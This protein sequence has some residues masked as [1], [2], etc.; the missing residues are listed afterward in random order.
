MFSGNEFELYSED[1]ITASTFSNVFSSSSYDAA[2]GKFNSQTVDEIVKDFL[3]ESC[4]G[5]DSLYIRS[6][7]KEQY[8]KAVR[9]KILE[10][11]EDWLTKLTSFFGW[12]NQVRFQLDEKGEVTYEPLTGLRILLNFVGWQSGKKFF[13]RQII[14]F[15]TAFIYTV[16]KNIFWVV[17]TTLHNSLKYVFEY[18]PG[19]IAEDIIAPLILEMAETMPPVLDE[20]INEKWDENDDFASQA[21]NQASN[22]FLYIL[23]YA[24]FYT[25]AFSL[26]AV[27][28]LVKGI[29][30][31]D[32]AIISP[33][34]SVKA[35]LFWSLGDDPGAGNYL[36]A[37]TLSLLSIAV[38][39]TVYTLLFPL[40]IAAA[41]G[42]FAPILTKLSTLLGSILTNSSPMLLFFQNSIITPLLLQLGVTTTFAPVVAFFSGISFVASL[43]VSVVGPIL[44]PVLQKIRFD[45]LTGEDD[46]SIELVDIPQ[47][48]YT[49]ARHRFDD[50]IDPRYTENKKPQP[51]N[52]G[53]I[54]MT[55]QK[56]NLVITPSQQS[57][58]TIINKTQTVT[59]TTSTPKN[60]YT[61]VR[62]IPKSAPTET[63]STTTTTSTTSTNPTTI[64]APIQE[65]PRKL[66]EKEKQKEMKKFQ[67]SIA[68][69]ARKAKL[70]E[71]GWNNTERYGARNETS[72]SDEAPKKY[73]AKGRK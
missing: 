45:W 67:K 21:V 62:G 40:L 4:K 12:P 39:T 8:E 33:V 36:L 53:P 37:I 48:D 26:S 16:P 1:E 60:K 7:L 41:P 56:P 15:V 55:M 64:T 73:Q 30:V 23:G 70:K 11:R 28:G 50:Y 49:P 29:Q 31:F 47:I 52:R 13:W 35:A 9:Q 17:A 65:S 32:R 27:Y 57:S 34:D 72:S 58:T 68:E 25:S 6:Q 54:G 38:T 63:T 43:V 10:Y 2:S 5:Q 42:L 22:Y 61:P 69:E 66:A 19:Y 71:M 14:N 20:I 51:Q 3:D 44:D 24:G 46:D 18:I 59:P